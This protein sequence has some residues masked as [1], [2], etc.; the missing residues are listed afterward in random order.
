MIVIKAW[1]HASKRY[2]SNYTLTVHCIFIN[3][4][5]FIYFICLFILFIIHLIYSIFICLYLINLFIY[6]YS[7]WPCTC[8]DLVW[9]VGGVNSSS[10]YVRVLSPMH[11]CLCMHAGRLPW[12][13]HWVHVKSRSIH[14]MVNVKWN[15]LLYFFICVYTLLGGKGVE[16]GGPLPNLGLC[17]IGWDCTCDIFTFWYAFLYL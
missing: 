12:H 8:S 13:G 7:S 11:A 2:F 17:F 5:Y 3:I 4:Y 14:S 16:G 15:A 1:C 9:D 10:T 6:F